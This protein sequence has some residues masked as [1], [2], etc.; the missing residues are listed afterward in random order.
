MTIFH[1][2]KEKLQILRNPN[3]FNWLPGIKIVTFLKSAYL[4]PPQ[5]DQH[6]NLDPSPFRID[7]SKR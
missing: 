7:S 4:P 2:L 3:N 1:H 6:N 5:V